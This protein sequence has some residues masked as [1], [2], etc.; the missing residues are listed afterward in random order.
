MKV[1]WLILQCKWLSRVRLFV[2]VAYQAPL[3]MGLSRQEYWSG[4]PFPSPGHLPNPGI[5]PRS[6]AL[7][8][9]SLPAELETLSK[10]AFHNSEFQRS[11]SVSLARTSE[12]R[13]S[14]P[15]V[16]SLI[17]GTQQQLEKKTK[18]TK[19]LLLILWRVEQAPNGRTVQV[20]LKRKLQ[21]LT[22]LPAEF[23]WWHKVP[24]F[25]PGF[26]ERCCFRHAEIGNTFVP[27][28]CI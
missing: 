1:H 3:S 21:L 28:T 16:E 4:L 8:E 24:T 27:N 12:A 10:P 19:N 17:Q 9:D 14:L 5:K 26:G 7:R 20:L 11:K 22:S 23:Q 25:F 13:T 18:Q 2:T 15:Q 6:P